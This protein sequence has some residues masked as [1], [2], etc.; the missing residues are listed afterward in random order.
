MTLIQTEKRNAV[1]E[2]FYD[3]G[4]IDILWDYHDQAIAWYEGVGSEKKGIVVA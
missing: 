3:G 2:L 1:P 4:E